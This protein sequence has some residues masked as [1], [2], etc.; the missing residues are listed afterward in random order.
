MINVQYRSH[1]VGIV[2]RATFPF[3]SEISIIILR[4]TLNEVCGFLFFNIFKLF[5]CLYAYR[6]TWAIQDTVHVTAGCVL[7][8][9]NIW[10]MHGAASVCYRWITRYIANVRWHTMSTSYVSMNAITRLPLLPSQN[11]DTFEGFSNYNFVIIFFNVLCYFVK[12][13]SRP[14]YV[15]V[16]VCVY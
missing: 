15:C 12:G 14:V 9:P 2:T 10:R 11:I 1:F 5:L 7:E 13:F 3:L 8:L 6:M 16:C 4:I